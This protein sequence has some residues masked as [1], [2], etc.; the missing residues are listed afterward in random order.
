MQRLR[1]LLTMLILL[2]A[3]GARAD[4]PEV[5]GTFDGDPMYTLLAPD[6]IP[7]IQDPTYL[8]GTAGA[9]QMS[10]DEPVM[11]LAGKSG[12]VAWSTWQLDRHE[13]VN[14]SFDGVPVAVTW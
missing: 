1:P 8:K 5:Y 2:L 14:D 12:A 6:G 4:G 7:A 13:I 11:A 3:T 10:A 9:A